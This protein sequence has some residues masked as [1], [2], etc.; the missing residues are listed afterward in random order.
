MRRLLPPILAVLLFVSTPALADA[1]GDAQSA[2]KRGDYE[3]AFRLFQPLAERGDV[4]AQSML[5]LMYD[6]GKG[7]PNNYVLAYM[8]FDLAAAHGDGTAFWSRN[9]VAA[10]MTA[11]Q[12]AEARR[13]AREWKPKQS[14]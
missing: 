9:T 5:G 12:I 10:K 7:V 11:A 13:L 14:P 3:T 1:L 4:S 8:W 2:Y 6:E